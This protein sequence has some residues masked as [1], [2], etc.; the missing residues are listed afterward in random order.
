MAGYGYKN[1][2]IELV[3]C[4][5]DCCSLLFP[6][7]LLKIYVLNSSYVTRLLYNAVSVFLSERQRNRI[8]FVDPYNQI[9]VLSL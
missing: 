8:F 9:N 1:F 6:S 4:I 3:K 5:I 7:C 2:N